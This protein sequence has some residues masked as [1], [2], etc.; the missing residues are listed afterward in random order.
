MGLFFFRGLSPGT[1]K[2]P[3]LNSK[4][5]G[6]EL[7]KG[8]TWFKGPPV[9]IEVLQPAFEEPAPRPLSGVGLGSFK[10]LGQGPPRPGPLKDATQFK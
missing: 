8:L 6:L 3:S 7:C 2:G 1:F 9:P 4:G 5:A 10:R